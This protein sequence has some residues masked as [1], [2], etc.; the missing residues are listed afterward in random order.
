MEE[1]LP[2]FPDPTTVPP[3]SALESLPYLS[4]IVNETLRLSLGI[5]SRSIRV[6]R[7]RDV[8]FKDMV[9]PK[10]S[11]F[12]MTSY[13]MHKNPAIWG[14][15]WAEFV[16]ERWIVDKETGEAPR[17]VLGNGNGNVK[18][19][20]EPLS[21]YLVAFG[22]GPRMCIGVNLARAELFIVLA[23]LFRRLGCGGGGGGGEKEG[24]GEGARME[25]FK[26]TREAVEM[27]ADYFIPFPDPKTEGVRVLVK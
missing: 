15:D 23:I 11:Y 7:D 26:T 25:L 17:V 16:P 20:G 1:L 14:G 24:E 27:K 4:G 13:Y 8:V 3:L 6:S 12:S 5:S 22:R 2:V 21:K 9:I 18:G 10:G 19:K